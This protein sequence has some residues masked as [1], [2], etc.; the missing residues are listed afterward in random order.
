MYSFGN[1]K[2]Y[3]I[4]SLGNI[5]C[6]FVLIFHTEKKDIF[7][8]LLQKRKIRKEIKF[9]EDKLYGDLKNMCLPSKYLCTFNVKQ[10][11]IHFKSFSKRFTQNY[12]SKETKKKV[13]S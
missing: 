2:L 6:L 4:M 11:S 10:K 13:Q 9:S 5:F 1:R 3:F 8:Q 12:L 7:V